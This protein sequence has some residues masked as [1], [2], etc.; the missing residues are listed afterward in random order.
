MPP[1][2][3]GVGFRLQTKKLFLTF[4]QCTV[5]KEV[6]LQN[7]LDFSWEVDWAIVCHE[8]HEDGSPHLHAVVNLKS[9]YRTILPAALDVLVGSHG[10]YQK[11]K[12]R[13]WQAVKYIIKDGDFVA[14]EGFSPSEFVDAGLHKTGTSYACLAGAICAN[15]DISEEGIYALDAGKFIRDAPK[16][17]AFRDTV[18]KWRSRR[19]FSSSI[20]TPI[21]LEP[22][23]GPSLQIAVWLNLNL[24]T[25]REFKQK[26]LY[27][28]G[29]R[30]VGKTHLI[31]Q[32]E[33]LIKLYVIPTSE[34]WY[35]D[36]ED[37]VYQLAYLDEFNRQKTRHFVMSWLAGSTMKLKKKGMTAYEKKQ[38]IPTIILSNYSPE[39]LYSDPKYSG[40]LEPLLCR[41]TVVTVPHG[42][43]ID[44]WRT[45]NASPP[46]SHLTDTPLADSPFSPLSYAHTPEDH[47]LSSDAMALIEIDEP[48]LSRSTY[49]TWRSDPPSSSID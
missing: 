34:D 39:Y 37:G 19:E 20:W 44:L 18:R 10:D 2:R 47:V 11:V 48:P 29:P 36:Y 31:N 41:L 4:P 30:D 38:N 1:R 32:L 17:M 49:S 12:G 9:V 23:T 22:L 33:A 27:I 25:P 21:P 26:Q 8:S 5:T 42:T 24:G 14:T 35:C 7:I 46:P 13:L 15:P 45:Y 40:T 6:L 16:L 3:S 28:Q 43:V